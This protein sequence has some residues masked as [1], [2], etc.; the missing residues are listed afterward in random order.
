MLNYN[1]QLEYNL[2]IKIYDKKEMKN[3]VS[4]KLNVFCIHDVNSLN[5]ELVKE[6]KSIV[7]NDRT[8]FN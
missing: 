8:K 1:R 4:S 6:I 5:K 2:A 7:L 3:M